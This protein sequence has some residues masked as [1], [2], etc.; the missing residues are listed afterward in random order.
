MD[1]LTKEKRSAVMRSIKGKN[2]KPELRLRAALISN[3]LWGFSCNEERLPGKPDFAFWQQKV[4]VFVEGCFWHGCPLHYKTPKSNQEFWREKV[5]K[6]MERDRVNGQKLQ[7]DDWR[8]LRVWECEVNKKLD[9]AVAEVG[10]LV[11]R[12]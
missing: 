11:S 2:T 10:R 4:A 7:L 6:N 12:G 3:G 8:V 1:T 9:A 5:R